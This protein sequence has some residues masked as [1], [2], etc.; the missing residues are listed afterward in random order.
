MARIFS[1]KLSCFYCGQRSAQTQGDPVRKWRCKHCEAVNYLDEVRFFYS[2]AFIYVH[3]Y[4]NWDYWDRFSKEILQ[5]LLP[6]KRIQ[7]W[8]AQEHPAIP[9]NPSTLQTLGCS[10]RHAFEISIYS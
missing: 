2:M 10:V 6:Q 4:A 8:T 1:K 5:I 9:S 7:T 3:I